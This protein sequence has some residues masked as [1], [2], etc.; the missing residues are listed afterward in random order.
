MEQVKYEILSLNKERAEARV[1]FK[2]PFKKGKKDEINVDHERV[3]RIPFKD[4]KADREAFEEILGQHATSQ[5]NKM[6]L[7]KEKAEISTDTSAFEDIL[8]MSKKIVIEDD[9]KEE[10]SDDSSTES[11]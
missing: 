4:G 3:V 5:Y 1:K 9:E 8:S 10:T 2:N 11:E 7:N 6:L